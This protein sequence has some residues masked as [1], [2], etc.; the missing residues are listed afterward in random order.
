AEETEV[1]DESNGGGATEEESEG[2]IFF[3]T[4]DFQPKSAAEETQKAIV[5]LS[6]AARK[7]VPSD[8]AAYLAKEEDA[9]E[10]GLWSFYFYLESAFP[11]ISSQWLNVFNEVP[12]SDVPLSHIP[13]SVYE[14]SRHWIKQLQTTKHPTFIMWALDRVLTDWAAHAQDT[15]FKSQ[16]ASFVALAIVVRSKPDAL[17]SILPMLRERPRYQGEDK[18]PVLVWTMAQAFKDDLSAGLYSWAHNLLPLV[19]NNQ[20]YS[21]QSVD[22]ILRFVEIILSKPDARTILLNAA[23]R[24]ENRL[25]P[26]SAFEILVRLT[27]HASSARVEVTERFGTIYPLLKEVAFAPGSNTLKQIF[28]FSLKL[29]GEGVDAGNPFLA[30]EATSIAISCVTE[31]VDC[32]KQWDILYKKNIEASVALLKKLVDGWKD[33][34]LKLQSDTLAVN[35]TVHNFRTKNQKA[36]TE[37]VSDCFLYKE[38]DK[39]CKL[40]LRRL[41]RGSGGLQIATAMFIAAAG[42]A[43]GGVAGAAL[44]LSS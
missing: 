11:E 18:L 30:N 31:N 34:S 4:E 32:F 43:A 35:D 33:H 13:Q 5:T 23:V 7:I 2:D 1:G 42:V 22:L 3:Y 39:S 44:V 28:T 19:D 27:F 29:A 15:C 12:S 21:P 17:T 41:F 26:P 6:E 24:E 25:I 38:A 8:L 9:P 10:L 37:G 36:I 14:T 40:I 16:V 20:S